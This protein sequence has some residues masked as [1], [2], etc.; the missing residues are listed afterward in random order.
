M[1]LSL[2]QTAKILLNYSYLNKNAPNF[3]SIKIILNNYKIVKLRKNY[4]TTKMHL[5]IFSKQK[6][7]VNEYIVLPYCMSRLNNIYSMTNNASNT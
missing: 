7:S 2:K 4:Y 3:H 6:T 5:K 1:T